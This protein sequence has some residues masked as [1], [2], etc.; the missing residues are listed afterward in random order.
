MHF[1]GIRRDK[2]NLIS[3]RLDLLHLLILFG[4]VHLQVENLAEKVPLVVVRMVR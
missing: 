2:P 1:E 4:D 3:L